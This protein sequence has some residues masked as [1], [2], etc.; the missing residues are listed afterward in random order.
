[1]NEK[2]KHINRKGTEYK[3][4]AYPKTDAAEVTAIKIF[5]GLIDENRVK[6]H[7]AKRDKYPNT[8][9]YIE[10]VDAENRSIGTIHVQVKTLSDADIKRGGYSSDEGFLGHCKDALEP[11]ILVGVDV[12]N[13]IAYWNEVTAKMVENLEKEGSLTVKL[14]VRN[15]ISKSEQNYYESWVII[16]NNRK[17]VIKLFSELEDDAARIRL[18][19]KIL[20]ENLGG[21]RLDDD[22]NVEKI[23]EFLD[24]YNNLMSSK[25]RIISR[26]YYPNARKYGFAYTHYDE[27]HL[28]YVI[29][30][31][32][33]DSTDLD[34]KKIPDSFI[35]K[36]VSKGLR[37][38]THFGINPVEKDPRTYAQELVREDL[39][40]IIER[41]GL[42]FKNEYLARELIFD[43]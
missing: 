38:V 39:I 27:K 14:P 42:G 15:V 16:L 35:D 37:A 20:S 33:K 6:T 29:Y 18:V 26:L 25:F 7:I 8:D 13:E 32:P 24:E 2:R 19:Q 3:K 41:G 31:I 43:I 9:G 34:I 22:I 4:A 23:Q 11:S 21:I 40:H 1:M 12:Q 17:Q 36:M 30:E 10:P 28:S 5:E